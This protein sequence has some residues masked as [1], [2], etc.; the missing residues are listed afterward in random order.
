MVPNL[1]VLQQLLPVFLSY[2]LSFVYVGIYWNNH[3]HMITYARRSV[4]GCYGR[5]FISCSG[6][7]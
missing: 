5:T 2:V 6:F 3:H 7:H 4:D 1:V